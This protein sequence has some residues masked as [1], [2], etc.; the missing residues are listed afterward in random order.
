MVSALMVAGG[1]CS[2]FS[3]EETHGDPVPE[4][5]A[6]D[7]SQDPPDAAPVGDAPASETEPPT[8]AKVLASGYADL[9]A[10]VATETNAYFVARTAGIIYQVRLD[11]TGGV[12]ELYKASPLGSPSSAAV[13]DFTIYATDYAK[14]MLARREEG[15]GAAIT[16]P[17]S[18]M[19]NPAAIAAG[20][21]AAGVRV[22]V[23][24][25]SGATGTVQQYD[26]ELNFVRSSNGTYQTPFDVAVT[27]TNIWWTES[28]A[29]KIWQG[30][31]D[32]A[33]A[34]AR[35]DGESGCESITADAQ[36]VYWTR[37][38]DGLVRMMVPPQTTVDS[39]AVNQVTPV[40][41]TSDASGVYWL[42]GD[43]KL[44]RSTRQTAEVP[45]QTLAKGFAV[46]GATAT[47]IRNIALTSKYV[48]WVTADGKVLRTDK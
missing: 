44:Q 35:I 2:T 38:Q 16:L 24:A 21:S 29:G 48:V 40:S 9:T 31:L 47:R 36:G 1:A 6:G 43:G 7:A 10:V 19:L 22:V 11:G 37:P 18:G 8:S 23:L 32:E 46:G 26:T 4:A 39:I 5:G 13:Y 34:D 33:Q 42:T 28:S 17:A 20:T 30:H 27:G 45:P 3:G 25:L 15:G 14:S 12:Q 41:I